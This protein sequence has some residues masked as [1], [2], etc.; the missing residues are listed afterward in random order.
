[1]KFPLYS[2]NSTLQYI[3]LK[4]ANSSGDHVP[5]ILSMVYA[6][7]PILTAALRSGP[8]QFTGDERKAQ[9]I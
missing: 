3:V 8:L 9:G 6:I 2:I 4:R 7:S 5:N 1:M